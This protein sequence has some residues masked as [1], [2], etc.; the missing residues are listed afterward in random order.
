MIPPMPRYGSADGGGGGGPRSEI[1]SSLRPWN[2]A[3]SQTRSVDSEIGDESE[4][5]QTHGPVEKDRA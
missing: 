3:A 1:L 4:Q 5:F 2:V